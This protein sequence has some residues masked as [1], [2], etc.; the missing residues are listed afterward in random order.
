MLPHQIQH[1][2]KQSRRNQHA[3]IALAE[4]VLTGFTASLVQ[5]QERVLG[6]LSTIPGYLQATREL[7][8]LETNLAVSMVP[9][10]PLSNELSTLIASLAKLTNRLGSYDLGHSRHQQI[11]PNSLARQHHPFHTTAASENI[12]SPGPHA[13]ASPL[14]TTAV[15]L[16]PP[17]DFGKINQT[18]STGPSRLPPH[19][20]T[21]P[22]RTYGL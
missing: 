20:Y 19:R 14:I 18:P 2:G 4:R 17:F 3:A 13:N 15:T 12:H 22:T 9:Y 5:Q 1:S 6:S 10:F 16:Q 11:C 7:F 21:A 8:N